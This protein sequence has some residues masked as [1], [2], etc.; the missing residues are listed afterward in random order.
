MNEYYKIK[1][2]KSYWSSKQGCPIG[3]KDMATKFETIN[4]VFNQLVDFRD[5]NLCTDKEIKVIKITE[6]EID[7]DNL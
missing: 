6:T 3:N 5:N 2:G 7:L 4:D 1:I